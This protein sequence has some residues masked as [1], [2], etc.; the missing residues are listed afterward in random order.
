MSQP[1]HIRQVFF[2]K[3]IFLNRTW[4]QFLLTLI[5]CWLE[6]LLCLYFQVSTLFCSFLD[7]FRLCCFITSDQR[8]SALRF[9]AFRYSLSQSKLYWVVGG[10][11]LQFHG[12]TFRILWQ[13]Q[14]DQTHSSSLTPLAGQRAAPVAGAGLDLVTISY[15]SDTC[16]F[17]AGVIRLQRLKQNGAHAVV[18]GLNNAL[19]TFY[20]GVRNVLYAA[21]CSCRW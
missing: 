18:N 17:M 19:S 8:P 13:L 7:S 2:E 9:I 11:S 5:D 14:P 3:F 1:M 6:L 4:M 15:S 21:E 12:A 10:S 16:K 20:W